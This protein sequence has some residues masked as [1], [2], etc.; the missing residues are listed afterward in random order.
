MSEVGVVKADSRHAARLERLV[1][2][3]HQIAALHAEQY[4]LLARIDADPPTTSL[5]GH[6]DKHWAIEDVACALRLSPALARARLAEATE[7]ARLPQALE[8]LAGGVITAAHTRA[9]TEATLGLPDTTALAIEA[10]VLAR[11]AEQS[12]GAF[13]AALRRAVLIEAAA[14]VAQQRTA[15][16]AERRVCLRPGGQGTT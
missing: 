14:T 16:L 1:E 11:A 3:E 15:N 12:V 6:A 5:P 13:R 4:R 7:M 8:L 9:L 10:R 2:L